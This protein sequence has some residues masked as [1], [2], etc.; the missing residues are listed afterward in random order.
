MSDRAQKPQVTAQSHANAS[1]ER[2]TTVPSERARDVMLSVG[3][4]VYTWDIKS[5]AIEWSEGAAELFCLRDDSRI[6][7]GRSFNSLLLSTTATSREDAIRSAEDVDHG[8]GVPFHLQY[9]LSGSEIGTASDIWLEDS[10]CWFADDDGNPE[11]AQGVVRI[12]NERRSLEERLDR[13]SRFDPLTG[14]YNRS[15]LNTCLEQVFEQVLQSRESAAFMLIGV[16][17]FDLINSVYGYEAGDAVIVEIAERLKANLRKVD[18]IGRFSGARLGIILDECDERSMLVAGHRVLNLLRDELVETDRGPIAI[19]AAVGG[20]VIPQHAS[21]PRLAFNG[22]HQALLESRRERDASVISYRPDPAREDAQR[23]S[24]AMAQKIV[25]ALK[26]ERIH[27][28]YQPVVDA[29]TH[30]VV[31]FE[32]L[33]RLE[34]EEGLLLTAGDFVDVAQ[35]LGLIRLVDH[36]A[37]DLALETLRQYP[38]AKL[39]LN[40]SNETAC[41]PEWLSKIAIAAF[42]DPD[43]VP[44]LIVEI[45]ESHAAESLAEA[46]RF[47]DSLHDLG[48]QV[49]LDDFGAGFTSFRNL[50]T[51]SFDIIKIDGYFARD[52][53]A[54]PN[55]QA[56]IKSLVDL[57]SLFDAKTVVEWVEDNEAADFLRDC[58]V[59]YLQGYKFGKPLREPQWPCAVYENDVV[60]GIDKLAV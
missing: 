45:T 22:A 36:H 32:A 37:L 2:R 52:L 34:S 38:L 58:G 20:V 26:Q 40:V 30:E 49:A 59:H 13:M 24:V 47:I 10:G 35:S 53:E 54:N 23:K 55:N 44:R 57:A 3:E 39:S 7:S 4:C 60:V 9:A 29:V 11:R 46:N 31:F 51:L 28:A 41:D 50:K 33:L 1:G 8:K 19:S 42:A 27:L 14:L 6:T 43:I 17:H 15:H 25:S 56:F 48:F 12:I 5:D 16:D 18:T 21:N